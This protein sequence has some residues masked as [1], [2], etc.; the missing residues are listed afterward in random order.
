MN[1]KIIT[2]GLSSAFLR[3]GGEICDDEL[4]EVDNL[5]TLSSEV[6][7]ETAL[8][9]VASG[10]VGGETLQF[11]IGEVRGEL[12]A[13]LLLPHE[14]PEEFGESEEFGADMLGLNM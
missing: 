7:G 8:C 6:S 4:L 3:F 9:C 1:K 5:R 13:S 11:L 14:N 12:L 10:E 2:D